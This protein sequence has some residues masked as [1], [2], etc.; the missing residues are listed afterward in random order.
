[1]ISLDSHSSNNNNSKKRNKKKL[2]NRAA[3]FVPEPEVAMDIAASEDEKPRENDEH[4]QLIEDIEKDLLT[5]VN[6]RTI[7]SNSI[8]HSFGSSYPDNNTKEP[9]SKKKNK[10]KQTKQQQKL[11]NH[12]AQQ[13]H[14]VESDNHPDQTTMMEHEDLQNDQEHLKSFLLIDENEF[15][16][17]DNIEGF[18]DRL[19]CHDYNTPIKV[20]SIFGPIGH[21]KSFTLNHVFY[22]C[23]EVFETSSSQDSCTVGVW[24]S[25]DKK[26]RIITLDTEGLLGVSANCQ[27]RTR[28]LLK[29]LAISDIVIYRT[30]SERLEDNLFTFLGDA[31]RVYMQHF[32]KEIKN[33]FQ[34]L[35]ELAGHPL[36]EMGPVVIIF[37]ETR[38]TEPLQE[39][40]NQTRESIIRS[41]FKT[42]GLPTEAFSAIEYVGIQTLVRP[43]NFDQLK[44]CIKRHLKNSFSR[45]PR[46]LSV[47]YTLLRVLNEKFNGDIEKTVPSMFPN[48]YLT[49]PITCLSCNSRCTNSMNHHRDGIG[50]ECASKCI[51]QHQ[52]NNHV[53]FCRACY[54]RGEEVEVSPKTCS[55]TESPILGLAKYAWSGQV[56]ECPRCGIIH[57]SRQYWFGNKETWES[58]VRTE[59]RHVWS[60]EL[61]RMLASQNTAQRVLDSVNYITETVTSISAKPTK[62]VSEWVAD[63]IAPSYWIP[64]SRILQCALCNCEFGELDQKHHCRLC[65]NGLCSTCSS[66]SKPVPERGW[67]ETSVRVCDRC[68]ERSD[69]LSAISSLPPI[70]SMMLCD[71]PTNNNNNLLDDMNPLI[72]SSTTNNNTSSRAATSSSEES[73]SVSPIIDNNNSNTNVFNNKKPTSS[74]SS[75]SSSSTSSNDNNTGLTTAISNSIPIP[76]K[77]N[78]HHHQA[79]K[80]KT[81]VAS[82]SSIANQA[83]SSCN[84]TPTPHSSSSIGSSG[85]S[86]STVSHQEAS[87]M[88]MANSNHHGQTKTNSNN[89]FNNINTDNANNYGLMDELMQC[90]SNSTTMLMGGMLLMNNNN[91][92]SATG[93][94]S[95][96]SGAI[97]ARKLGE[98]LQSTLKT[99]VSTAIDYPLG[100][101]KDSARPDYW[102]PDNQIFNC[103]LCKVRFNDLIS[104]HHCRRCGGGF[105]QECSTKSMPVPERGWPDANVRV[106]DKCYVDSQK[107]SISI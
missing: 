28:L 52:F 53:L 76:Q 97:T 79:H 11:N 24:A 44:S 34:N 2:S 105:C 93:E 99:V 95:N 67:G 66:K 25:Y 104:I 39:E 21:G 45:T 63:Q 22:D 75:S 5:D 74:A 71:G 55:S 9:S 62:L 69:S 12:R 51:Y 70:P 64:N 7:T 13:Q 23:Q 17:I 41:R 42:L 46:H 14:L 72:S 29:V 38:D 19:G 27:R 98:V 16:Q 80:N 49:C 106:C 6:E 3:A 59:I 73:S 60:G 94:P 15:M 101:I 58:S 92:N 84:P 82:P 43:T 100:V 57:R 26:R 68:Y 30:R 56:L 88:I 90:G 96:A 32:Y 36:S 54:E 8:N 86:G 102:L 87:S 50:H 10:Q 89:S 31:S 4:D 85:S 65:G 77:N 40:A 48:Q 91:N 1:M 18:A 35:P 47:I 37:Q 81:A 103:G 83:G 33:A 20:V 78:N 107:H 61:N